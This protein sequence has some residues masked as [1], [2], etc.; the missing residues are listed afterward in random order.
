MKATI[1]ETQ[2]VLYEQLESNRSTEGCPALAE[3][4]VEGSEVVAVRTGEQLQRRF[5]KGLAAVG[6]MSRD[7]TPPEASVRVLF[8]LENT[9][10]CAAEPAMLPFIFLRAKSKYPNSSVIITLGLK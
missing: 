5:Q 1:T 8:V 7:I 3:G 10:S 4:V 6:P 9:A 2:I